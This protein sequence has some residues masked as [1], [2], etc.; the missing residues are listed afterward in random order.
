MAGRNIPMDLHLE[1]MN[2]RLKSTMRNM[3]SNM[4]ESSVRLAAECI[5]V[6]ESICS[7]FE[8]HTSRCALNSQKHSSPS[9]QRDFELMLHCLNDRQVYNN[10]SH[11][12]RQHASFK[13]VYNLLL[14]YDYKK[15]ISWMKRKIPNIV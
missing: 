3:G 10:T 9:F 5:Q 7:K 6:V 4:T 2:R 8:E 12:T 13:F 1:H 15:L 11:G 14:Q